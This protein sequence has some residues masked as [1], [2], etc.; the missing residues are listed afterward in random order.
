MSSKRKRDV[1]ESF[2][3]P[4]SKQ[5][6]ME[7]VTRSG[8]VRK[9]PAKFDDRVDIDGKPDVVP[10]TTLVETPKVTIPAP[11]VVKPEPFEEVP[12]ADESMV[13]IRD[14]MFEDSG[15]KGSR[16]HRPRKKSAKVLEMEEFE[17]AEKKSTTVKKEI[18]KKVKSPAALS[19]VITGP[20]T[21]ATTPVL[22]IKDI[23]TMPKVEPVVMPT[24]PTQLTPQKSPV[25]GSSKLASP[26]SSKTPPGNKGSVIK[27]LLSSPTQSAPSVSAANISQ[28]TTMTDTKP[29][30]SAKKAKGKGKTPAS[31]PETKVTSKIKQALESPGPGTIQIQPRIISI[32]KAA[33]EEDLEEDSELAHLETVA[34][35]SRGKKGSKKVAVKDESPFMPP[36]APSPNVIH[37]GPMNIGLEVKQENE[38]SV[39]KGKKSKVK[40][41]QAKLDMGETMMQD[42]FGIDLPEI[43][44]G[45]AGS[46][47]FMD[48]DDDE[49][50][51]MIPEEEVETEKPK[52]IKVG[53]KKSP[54]AK[55]K[56]QL[57]DIP[58][59]DGS[60]LVMDLGGDK[61]KNI[62]KKS[63][64][65]DDPYDSIVSQLNKKK[66]APT[67]YMMW[68]SAN[69]SALVYDNP[70]MDFS[71]ISKTL[72]EMWSNLSEKQKLVWKRKAKKAAGKGSTLI[73]TGKVQSASATGK[74]PAGKMLTAR[75]AAAVSQKAN[76]AL[77]QALLAAKQ[78]RT[79]VLDDINSPVKGFG[80]EPVDVAAH[81][82]IV[83]ESLSIIGMKLQEHRGLIAVQGSLSVLLDSMLCA[84]APLMCLTA[85]LP[86]TDGLPAETHLKTLDNIAYIM[87]GL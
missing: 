60:E 85:V 69:R 23:P 6:K 54:K 82:K 70:G 66:R 87:P 29:P 57:G 83:G 59:A 65:F 12:V 72:G 64:K 30:A 8:R 33:A 41:G 74:V 76:P 11:A 48:I 20:L 78:V 67:A 51:L 58:S 28:L 13:D 49:D 9:K 34:H 80:I 4:S 26:G 43:E 53:K 42:E 31:V 38:T 45:G 86:E 47:S 77:A 75:Q 17:E 84:V 25:A 5:M 68:C 44:L 3:S 27:L 32:K 61:K 16:A 18:V 55:G 50:G 56:V 62:S 1:E 15:S 73:T 79:P 14:E 35:T 2:S 40:G 7:E 19:G 24:M 81:L 52:I 37:V 71:T 39:K 21:I 46:D 10:V 22:K 36:P 63:A